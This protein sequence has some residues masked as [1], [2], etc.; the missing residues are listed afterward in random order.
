MF[1]ESGVKLG[2][3]VLFIVCYHG[4]QRSSLSPLARSVN[5]EVLHN[6]L[7]WFCLSI[8]SSQKT[9]KPLALRVTVCTL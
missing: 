3:H 4:C 9:R 2:F 5:N 7:L 6:S 1:F 8:L